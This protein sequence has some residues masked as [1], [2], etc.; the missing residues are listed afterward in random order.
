LIV[1]TPVIVLG[2]VYSFFYS[3]WKTLSLKDWKAF[4]LFWWNLLNNLFKSLAV[5]IMNFAIS[6]DVIANVLGGEMV[7][8]FTTHKE[9]TTFGDPITISASIG[10][11]EIKGQLIKKGT[12]LSRALNVVFNQRSH[13]VDSWLIHLKRKQLT[14]QFFKPRKK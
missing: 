12:A 3:I 6:Y 13:A 8:D 4:F 7:E 2:L 11:S 10:E 5:L 9:E 1:F 14:N